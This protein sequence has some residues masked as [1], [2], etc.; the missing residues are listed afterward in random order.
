MKRK[1]R[2][3]TNKGAVIILALALIAAIVFSMYAY[4]K[5]TSTLT[6]NGT[7]Q[8]AKWSFKVNGETQTI[9]DI[10]L[11]S[12]I[13]PHNNVADKKIAPGTSGHFD[14]ILDGTGS[15]VAIDYIIKLA[16]TEKP[17]NLKFYTDSAYQKEI[18]ETDGTL[19]VTGSIPLSDINTPLTRPIYWQWPYQTGETSNDIKKNDETDTKDSVKKITMAITVTGAQRN[20]ASAEASNNKKLADVVSIGDYVNYDASSGNGAGKSYTTEESLTGSSTTATF[21]SNETMKWKVMSV[22]KQTG[23]VEL[24]AENPT[25]NTV[26]L[27]GKAG[28][29][30]TVTV[31]DKVG[32]VYGHGNGATK[33]R[34]ITIE[35]VN[36]LENYT[37]EDDTTS[38]TYTSGTFI[39]DDGTETVASS[40]NTVTMKYT[41]STANKSTNRWYGYS[42][43][44]FTNKN[45]WLASTC[46]IL[47]PGYLPFDVRYVDSGNVSYYD[48]FVSCDSQRC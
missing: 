43:T 16:I 36:K 19:N 22:D 28:Y 8:V 14:L 46:I 5:Y 33:G 38:R 25:T 7:T 23:T 4:A 15:E 44:N 20:P 35:D 13:D 29:K 10:D 26:T 2:T 18:T 32:D 39:N 34:S 41:K 11:T 48:L 21:N 31:L 47:G 40:S 45:F 17:T 27:Y 30:N 3:S 1:V 42:T 6:G 37:P 9:P 12:T 24:M